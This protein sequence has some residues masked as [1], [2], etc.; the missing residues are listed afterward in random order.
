MRTRS[1]TRT[2]T[3]S[4]ASSARPLSTKARSCFATLASWNQSAKPRC[5]SSLLCVLPKAVATASF[6]DRTSPSPA[7]SS[8]KRSATRA[9]VAA[10]SVSSGKRSAP[11]RL[12]SKHL[13]SRSLTAR[14]VESSFSSQVAQDQRISVSNTSNVSTLPSASLSRHSKIRITPGCRRPNTWSKAARSTI[15]VGLRSRHKSCASATST[16]VHALRYTRSLHE[17]RAAPIGRQ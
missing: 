6:S 7:G 5:C 4:G 1:R 11:F 17:L 14:L 9:A 2:S 15:M 12:K 13:K 10:M 8:Q 3:A 16:A